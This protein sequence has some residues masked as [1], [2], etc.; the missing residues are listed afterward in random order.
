MD[1]LTVEDG[2]VLLSIPMYFRKRRG[3]MAMVLEAQLKAVDATTL[4]SD[5]VLVEYARARAFLKMLGRADC[6][7]ATDIAV[8]YGIDRGNFTRILRMA[9]ISPRIIH[10]IMQGTAPREVSVNRLQQLD[11]LD[12]EEQER[13]VGIGDPE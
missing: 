7:N 11:M 1:L 2:D 12:W 10:A 4:T 9:L 8:K 13:A 6:R 3:K 5:P